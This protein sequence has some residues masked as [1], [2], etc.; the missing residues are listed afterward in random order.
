[1]V[2][3]AWIKDALNESKVGFEARQHPEVFT[4]SQVAEKEKLDPG[5]VAKVVVVMVHDKPLAL[6]LPAN[7]R[8]SIKTLSKTLNTGKIRLATEDEMRKFFPDCDVGALP[9]LRHWENLEFWMDSSMENPTGEIVFQAG[10]HK[11]SIRMRFDD[12][13]KLVRPRV[14]KFARLKSHWVGS[15][16]L[17]EEEKEEWADIH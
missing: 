6:I 3:V 17:D 4:A 7:R 12:W 9:P 14:E 13:F 5:E 16:E 1:M 11:D 2:N 10:T 8:V 15:N